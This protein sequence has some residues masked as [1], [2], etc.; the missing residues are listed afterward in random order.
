MGLFDP[1]FIACCINT[2]FFEAQPLARPIFPLHALGSWDTQLPSLDLL[3][4]LLHQQY[5]NF[6]TLEPANMRPSNISLQSDLKTPNGLG[7]IGDFTTQLSR[8]I[9]I[10]SLLRGPY[11]PRNGGLAG[12]PLTCNMEP[13]KICRKRRFRTLKTHHFRGSML[14]FGGGVSVFVGKTC[15]TFQQ[16]KNNHLASILRTSLP[17]WE[18]WEAQHGN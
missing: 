15:H 8:V 11:S 17:L 13:E 3:S 12:A 7:Y 14:N 18:V 4:G 5:M 2:G 10:Q 6:H 1:F 9:L 16:T